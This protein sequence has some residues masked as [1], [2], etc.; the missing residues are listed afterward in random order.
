GFAYTLQVVAQ[1][2]AKP[3]HAAI[4]LSLE[5]VFAALAGWAFLDE[6]ISVRGMI[7][8]ALMLLG[9]SASQLWP[10]SRVGNASR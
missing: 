8:C 7:G 3:T 6:T 1:R 4:L 2:K 9:M 5:A 10:R